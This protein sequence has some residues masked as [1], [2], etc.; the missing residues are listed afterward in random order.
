[1]KAC[2]RSY[3]VSVHVPFSD[4]ENRAK[5]KEDDPIT[6]T[7]VAK[8]QL[9]WLIKKGDLILSNKPKEVTGP[10]TMQFKESSPRTGSILIYAY[11]RD[12]LPTSL[13]SC[14]RGLSISLN[15]SMFADFSQI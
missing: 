3:G 12:K 4:V 6:G 13:A 5:D 7:A 14:E 1:M 8:D 15:M 10:V 2:P 11:D 9:M